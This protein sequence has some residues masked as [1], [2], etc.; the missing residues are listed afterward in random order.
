MK[1]EA[2]K[3]G[4]LL[5]KIRESVELPEQEFE[6]PT[7]GK[8]RGHATKMPSLSGREDWI[9][10]PD[11]PKCAAEK[12]EKEVRERAVREERDR[13]ERFRAMNIGEK[14]WGEDFST[15]NA[16]SPSLKKYLQTCKDFA[17]NP[18]EKHL[19]MLGANGNGK[20]HLA[21]SILKQTGGVIYTAFE[22]GLR[23]HAAYNGYESEW[24]I[25]KELCETPVLVIDEVDRVKDSEFGH[26]WMSHVMGERYKH[27]LPI[28]FISNCHMQ[29]DCTEQEKPCPK[30]LEYHLENDV[31]SRIYESGA[32]MKFKASDYRYKKRMAGRGA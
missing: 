23:L 20:T 4:D 28:I 6:C 3:I 17:Q 2:K 16:Y 5:P 31:L 13:I 12:A 1:D 26:H 9:I 32:L 21:A 19:V 18:K 15:F 27:L 22:I 7:H 30:C 24:Q 14:F 10:Q 8:F 11:C 25:F 29:D